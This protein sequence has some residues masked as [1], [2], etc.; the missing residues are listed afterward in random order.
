MHFPTGS[1]AEHLVQ[2]GAMLKDC[3]FW[4]S[5]TVNQVPPFYWVYLDCSYM[6]LPSS[7]PPSLQ[8]IMHRSKCLGNH[9]CFKICRDLRNPALPQPDMNRYTAFRQ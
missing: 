7:C 3:E 1:G 8:V 4:Y 5:Y 9:S 2:Q 6:F